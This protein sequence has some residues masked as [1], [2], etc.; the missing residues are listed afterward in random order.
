MSKI[1]PDINN[2]TSHSVAFL[3]NDDINSTLSESGIVIRR[4]FAP[5]L[6][7]LYKTQTKYKIVVNSRSKLHK[8]SV[9]QIFVINH[10]QGDDIIIGA[11]AVN[12]SAYIVFG[13]STLA[14]ETVNGLALWAYGMILLN[15]SS[16]T[17]RNA[18]VKK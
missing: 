17:S 2:S 6:R 11:T 13:N 10:R 18:T 3:L 15:R 14:L 5:M 9:G 1:I 12:K 4:F 16:K 8:T 7:L